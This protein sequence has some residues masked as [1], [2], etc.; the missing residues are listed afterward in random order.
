MR[1]EKRTLNR[2]FV[3]P[4]QIV[5]ETV[6]FSKETSLQLLKVLR[7]KAGGR[8]IVLDNSGWEFEVEL[9][10]VS[11]S[12]LGR[13][14]DKRLNQAEPTS[15]LTL[16][17]SVLKKDK[18]EW[19][20]QKC[21]ELGVTKFVPMVSERSG[22]NEISANKIARWERIIQ[23]AAEQCGRG[24]LPVLAAS[25]SFADA[26]G[27]GE[28]HGVIPHEKEDG[29]Y[30]SDLTKAPTAIFIG[31]EGGFSNAEIQLA[32]THNITPISLGKRVL[33]A[34]TAAVATTSFIQI[35]QPF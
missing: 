30:L 34:E 25:M 26:V 14:L 11:R 35:N 20:L 4:E 33:R 21:T 29:T 27:L 19:V 23:E 18:F 32:L 12:S 7:M 31:P 1:D 17:Q 10:D 16:Y 22:R 13:I 2:F 28:E 6:A 9:T 3:L 15:P 5:G 24:K 8:V